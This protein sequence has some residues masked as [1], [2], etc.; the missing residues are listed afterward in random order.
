MQ[1]VEGWFSCRCSAVLGPLAAAHRASME[2]MLD[3]PQR[4]FNDLLRFG[5]PTIDPLLSCRYLTRW[6]LERRAMDWTVLC[7]IRE[8][9][10]VGGG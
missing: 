2:L 7:M 1:I 10:I 4:K 6:L 5:A 8:Q 9:V 3:N